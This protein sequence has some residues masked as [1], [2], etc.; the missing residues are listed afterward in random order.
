[1]TTSAKGLTVSITTPSGSVTRHVSTSLAI[2][3]RPGRGGVVIGADDLTISRTAVRVTLLSRSAMVE[4]LSTHA[5]VELH[6]TGAM[7][8]LQPGEEL[9]LV[10]DS[11]VVV[12]GSAF[13]FPIDIM[14]VRPPPRPRRPRS[15]SP[16]H[17]FLEGR[18]DLP[19]ARMQAL[20]AL[21]L[22][23]FDPHRW[24]GGLLTSPEIAEQLRSAG[25]TT[26]P[27]EIDNKLA[28]LRDQVSRDHGINLGSRAELAEFALRHGIVTMN[29][30][31]ALRARQH[32]Y[33]RNRS[34][35][36]VT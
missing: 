5:A 7:R 6:G 28:R 11:R 32:Q 33:T 24:P 2:G 35:R 36:G 14:G 22:P 1:M 21:C 15:T 10:G 12:T 23:R 27:K 30:I 13:Q 9:R 16:T 25:L 3:R 18:R 8:L 20:V 34:R 17:R 31:E 19:D 29:D 4:N 26:T